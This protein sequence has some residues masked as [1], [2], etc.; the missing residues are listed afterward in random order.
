MNPE[1]SKVSSWNARLGPD[2]EYTC[3]LMTFLFSFLFKIHALLNVK[4]Y[5]TNLANAYVHAV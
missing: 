1:L 2:I 4:Y 5:T 3:D